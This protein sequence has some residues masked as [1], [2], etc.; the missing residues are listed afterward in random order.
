MGVPLLAACV[1]DAFVSVALPLVPGV[2]EAP[3]VVSGVVA[4]LAVPAAADVP[5]LGCA[6]AAGA[7]AFASDDGEAASVPAAAATLIPTTNVDAT[8]LASNVRLNA[9]L[10]VF[11]F[12]YPAPRKERRPTMR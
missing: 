11:S 4:V 12:E 3:P 2:V 8:R 1:V 7:A 6:P 5:P 9:L 10:I